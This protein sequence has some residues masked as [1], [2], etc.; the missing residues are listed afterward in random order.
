M[1]AAPQATTATP[2][3]T[4]RPLSLRTKAVLITALPILTLGFLIA[5]YLTAHNRAEL[6]RISSSLSSAVA[7]LLGTTLDVTDLTQVSTQLRAAVNA[8]SVAFIDVQPAGDAPRAFISDTPSTDWLLRPQL[9][10]ALRAHPGRTHFSWPDTRADAYRAA[11]AT[12]TSSTPDSVRE[13]LQAAQATLSATRGQPQTFEVT[14][15]DVYD[16]PQGTR[17]LRLPGQAAP[18]GE[19][20]FRLTI[21]VTLTDLTAALHRQLL[22]VLSACLITAVTAALLAWTAARRVVTLLLAI[23][24]AAQQASL[25]Q[26]HEPVHIPRRGRPDEL[27]DLIGAIERLRVSLHLALNRLRPGSRP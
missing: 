6:S 16:T 10:A 5:A 18:P 15:L 27:S 3:P 14:Q 20:L 12:L 23:T 25:G 17:A 19:R 9:D 4:P 24:H 21:G 7:S 2:A 13:H 8:P 1:T 22:I 11:Q 26:L